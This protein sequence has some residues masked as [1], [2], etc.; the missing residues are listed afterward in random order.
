MCVTFHLGV[1][2]FFGMPKKESIYMK[3]LCLLSENFFFPGL[4][5]LGTQI[6]CAQNQY[7]AVQTD[8]KY[9]P[10]LSK[11]LSSKFSLK[12]HSGHNS[13]AGQKKSVISAFKGT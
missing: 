4:P 11:I 2:H 6:I 8:L 12:I 10:G 1:V 7:T 13:G 5:N 3:Y 9:T